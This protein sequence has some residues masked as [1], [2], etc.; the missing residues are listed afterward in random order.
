LHRPLLSLVPQKWVWVYKLN[1]MVG[2]I[3]G[4]RCALFN[5][6][7]DTG[8]ILMSAVTSIIIFIG[9][10]IFFKKS[11]PVFSDIV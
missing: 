7:F 1:P 11:E 3:E 10:Y 5:Y 9:G 4:Y 8:T 6:P 2:I